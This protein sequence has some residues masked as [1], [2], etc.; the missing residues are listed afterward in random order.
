MPL[1]IMMIAPLQGWRQKAPTPQAMA[2]EEHRFSAGPDG[3]IEHYTGEQLRAVIPPES[4]DEYAKA[5]PEMQALAE[6]M[7]IRPSESGAGEAID[8]PDVPPGLPGAD[9]A[10]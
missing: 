5:W 9:A 2:M 8:A 4:W 7:R 3:Q 10:P 6:Q 1:D